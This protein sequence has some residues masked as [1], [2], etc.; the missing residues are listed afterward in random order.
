VDKP[1]IK[2]CGLEKEKKIK[3]SGLAISGLDKI[4]AVPTVGNGRCRNTGKPMNN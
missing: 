2:I 1:I 4:L 3:A